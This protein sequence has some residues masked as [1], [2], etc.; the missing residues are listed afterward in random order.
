VNFLLIHSPSSRA[1][2]PTGCL[3]AL[4]ATTTDDKSLLAE[5]SAQGPLALL[6]L[7]LPLLLLLLL[8]LSGSGNI[9]PEEGEDADLVVTAS[10]I[11]LV[12]GQSL[13]T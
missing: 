10:G 1:K 6:L 7:L 9:F 2:A 8:L 13:F 3:V 4:L 12:T 11:A 5:K